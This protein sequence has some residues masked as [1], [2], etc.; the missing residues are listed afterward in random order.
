MS[1]DERVREIDYA[2]AEAIRIREAMEK[3]IDE[4]NVIAAK[5]SVERTILL[6]DEGVGA[7]CDE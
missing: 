1:K 6:F 2:I 5:L 7:Y 4:L 3:Q